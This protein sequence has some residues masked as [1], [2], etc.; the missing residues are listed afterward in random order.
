[1]SQNAS[2]DENL[3]REP[4]SESPADVSQPASSG[5]AAASEQSA[6]TA[7]D[8]SGKGP[9]DEHT[10]NVSEMFGRMTPWYDLQNRVFSLFLD[11][12]WRRNLVRSVVPG[13]TNTV[14]DMAAGTLDVTLAL[15]RRYP[16]LHVYATD[17]CEPMLRYGE[18]RKMRAGERSRV[19]TMVADARNMP[20]PDGCADAVTIAF[21]IRNV[22]PRMDAL[23][24]M[25]RLLVP[26]GRACILEFAP[27]S[28]PLFG[29]C[30]HWYLRHVMPKLAG[31]VSHSTSAYDYF[32]ETIENFPKPAAFSEELREAGFA[33][34]Q[35]IPFTLGVANLHIAV[36]G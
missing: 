21:G 11:C 27:V 16:G 1:M 31:L 26:G 12:W 29:P 22:R 5:D 19:T 32:A 3:R 24:E 25:H 10:R 30:Y 7:G 18:E 33:F 15:I 23:R 2:G 20:L 14:I 4:V 17:I 6:G 8:A 36:R 9:G 13:P 34:V 28:T 35:H